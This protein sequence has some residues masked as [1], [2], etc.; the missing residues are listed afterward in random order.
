[1]LFM[2]ACND[3]KPEDTGGETEE[4]EQEAAPTET[5]ETETGT[6]EVEG[7]EEAVCANISLD[8]CGAY[9][10]CELVSGYP[11]V[12]NDLGEECI[13]SSVQEPQACVD[14]GCSAEPTITIAHPPDSDECWM[15]TS[16]C[17]PE[18]WVLCEGAPSDCM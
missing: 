12:L 8:E 15:F 4:S 17:L 7:R 14:Y 16:G 6:P 9:E 5:E 18:G 3:T 11:V 2:L 13:D 10:Q 1:M